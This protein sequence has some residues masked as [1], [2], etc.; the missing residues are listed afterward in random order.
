MP[1]QLPLGIVLR[2]N[3][4]FSNYVPGQNEEVL[5]T[6]QQTLRSG[7]EQFVYLWGTAGNGKTHLLHAACHEVSIRGLSPVYLP[8]AQRHELAPQM[9]EG[10]E[11]LDLV[12]LD[13]IQCIAGD[14]AWEGALFHLYNR[15]RESG[16]PLLV[17]GDNI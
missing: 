15:L 11:Q 2:D 9:L 6:V 16:H 8:L 3:A 14:E 7:G 10:L 4:T 5:H 12:C 13:D 17:A 1:C